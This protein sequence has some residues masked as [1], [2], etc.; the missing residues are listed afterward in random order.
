M[1]L[2]ESLSNEPVSRLA[3]REPVLCGPDELIRDAVARMREQ[4]LGCVIVVDDQ[5]RPVGMFT[6]NMLTRLM[7][8]S[9][10][11]LDDKLRARMAEQCHCVRPTDPVA[12]VLEALQRSNTRFVCVVDDEGRVAGLTG[13]KGLMEF[14]AEHF[15]GQVMVQ[16]VGSPPPSQREGA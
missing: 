14:I 6:E 1:Q 12:R 9:P 15:P 13:Q 11:G 3:L 7:A 5:S 8:S 2:R 10:A 16:R 4:K